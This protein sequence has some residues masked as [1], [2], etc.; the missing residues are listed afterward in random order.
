[1][2]VVSRENFNRGD[3]VTCLMFTSAHFELRK[4]LPN[5]VPSRNGEL[6][7][8]KDCVAQCE[9]L[10]LLNRWMLDEVSGPI[11][12]LDDMALRDV[13]RAVGFVIASDCEPV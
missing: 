4:G 12:T 3:Y 5:C 7:L 8:S 10:T 2:L 13:I 9:T 6:G 1:M 11:G